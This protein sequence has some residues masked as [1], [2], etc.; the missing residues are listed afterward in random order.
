MGNESFLRPPHPGQLGLG[1]DIL[2][3]DNEPE[4]HGSGTVGNK[5]E[6]PSMKQSLEKRTT[7]PLPMPKEEKAVHKRAIS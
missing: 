1:A 3:T 2:L 4:Q 7:A 5:D 6:K